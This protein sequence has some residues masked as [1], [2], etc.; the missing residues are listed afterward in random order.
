MHDAAPARTRDV[1]KASSLIVPLF[2]A[3]MFLS[4]FLLF[5]VEPMVAKMVLPILGG[6]PMVWNGCVVFFQ[7]VMLAGYGYAFGASRWLSVR[8]HVMLHAVVLAAPV[9][10]LPI[11]IQAGAGTI[12]EGNPLGWLLLLLA[13]SIGLPFFVLSTSA[14]VLQHWLSRTDHPSARDPY[15]LY[16]ASNFGCLLALACYPT[17][18]EPVFTLHEQTR[19]WAIGYAEF[20]LLAGVCAV[21]A[22]RRTGQ[23]QVHPAVADPAIEVAGTPVTVWRRAR[24]VALALVPSSLMLAVTSY[25]STDIAAVP[26]LWIVPLA[27]YLLTFAL[28]FGRHSEAVGAIARRALPLLVVPLALVMITKVR[29]PLAVIVALHLAAFAVIAF[30]CHAELAKDRPA[31]SRLTEFYFWV[32]FGGMVGGLFNTLA[33]PFLFDSIVEYP[34]MVL[35]GCLMFRASGAAVAVGRGA[36]DVVMPLVV[37]GVTAGIFVA[38]GWKHGIAL[39]PTGSALGACARHVRSAAAPD[40]IWIVHGGARP[41]QPGIRQRR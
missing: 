39:P 26:L 16:A 4:G 8:H 37:A 19:L 1:A 20:V 17:V 5:V 3:T 34:L 6:V 12:P 13:R 18:V 21:F 27:L 15:F 29:A 36:A 28:A 32:S 41:R 2:A 9:V 14:S 38:V 24:W 11:M 31:P 10:V 23:P 40:P 33:A 7:I 22:W 25:I 35:L 30:N